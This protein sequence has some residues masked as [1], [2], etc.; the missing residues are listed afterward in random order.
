MALTKKGDELRSSLAGS[1]DRNALSNRL[2][3]A[4]DSPSASSLDNGPTCARN[5][6]D[7]S[8]PNKVLVYNFLAQCARISLASREGE[9]IF[10][11]LWGS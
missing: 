11:P 1:S 7:E 2:K 3:R 6:P 9:A 10:S 4:D 8:E 5:N